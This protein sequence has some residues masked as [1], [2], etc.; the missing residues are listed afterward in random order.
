MC[1]AH[2][3]VLFGEMSME[4]FCHFLIGLFLINFFFLLLGC[5]SSIYVLDINPLLGVPW[6]NVFFY[7]I[8]LLCIYNLPITPSIW[9]SAKWSWKKIFYC[10]TVII[11]SHGAKTCLDL[12]NPSWHLENTSTNTYLHYE[13]PWTNTMQLY[14]IVSTLV[15]S[16]LPSRKLRWKK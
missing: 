2:L 12:R 11:W 6:A 1:I 8:P 14:N 10:M 9:S 16:T 7:S 5:I 13:D 15:I 3:Y 4:V